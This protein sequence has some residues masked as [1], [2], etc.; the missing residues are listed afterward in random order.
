[1]ATWKLLVSTVLVPSLH[2]IYTTLALLYGGRV[3]AVAYFFFSPFVFY[4][5]IKGME[6]G[7]SV[8]SIVL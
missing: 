1:M 7:W 3:V 8:P 2:F 5:G 6:E 4:L